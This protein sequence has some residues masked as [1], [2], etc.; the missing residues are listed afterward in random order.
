[1]HCRARLPVRLRSKSGDVRKVVNWQEALKRKQIASSSKNALLCLKCSASSG[2]ENVAHLRDVKLR[3]YTEPDTVWW[4]QNRQNEY[5]DM[6]ACFIKHLA[7]DL[8]EEFG[9]N[10]AYIATENRGY[11][12]NGERHPHS[13]S[14]VDVADLMRWITDK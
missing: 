11:R 12:S 14:I 6:N 13:W 5:E 4:K 10:V 9:D 3:F 7:D 1:M 8:S 2:T